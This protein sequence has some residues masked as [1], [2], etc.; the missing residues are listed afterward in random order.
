MAKCILMHDGQYKDKVVRVPD[1]YARE[2]VAADRAE[3]KPRVDWKSER[4]QP[5]GRV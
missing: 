4:I 2:L 1:V 3:Y 5:K